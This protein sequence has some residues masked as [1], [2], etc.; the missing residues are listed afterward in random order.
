MSKIFESFK[1]TVVNEGFDK[2]IAD[3]IG[4][5]EIIFAENTSRMGGS[6]FNDK[7]YLLNGK[8]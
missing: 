7:Y 6:F 5:D 2:N 3:Y 8:Y 4:K 1:E